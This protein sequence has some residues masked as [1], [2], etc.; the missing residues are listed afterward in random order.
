MTVDQ[1][2]IQGHV[3]LFDELE[4]AM[5]FFLGQLNALFI[6]IGFAH[7]RHA[8]AADNDDPAL[9]II[10][11][12][13]EAAAP[14]AF[15]GGGGMPLVV[16]AGLAG[17]AAG[18]GAVSVPAR[19]VAGCRGVLPR[20]IGGIAAVGFYGRARLRVGRPLGNRARVD[21]YGRSTKK[22]LTFR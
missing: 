17:V 1:I 13:L 22:P 5:V 16:A 4:G 3:F 14:A 6:D 19:R 15:C 21:S 10:N 2:L 9:Q 11:R 12:L 7:V 18:I 8:F 20:R